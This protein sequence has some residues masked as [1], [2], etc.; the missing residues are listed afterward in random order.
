MK[1]KKIMAAM[2][3]CLVTW[4]SLGTVHAITKTDAVSPL[5]LY[6]QTVIATL[7]ISG[8]GYATCCGKIKTRELE[9]EIS[10]TVTLYRQSGK[11]WIRVDGWGNLKT[12]TNMLALQKRRSVEKG[13]YMVVVTGWVTPKEGEPESVRDT[14]DIITY[15]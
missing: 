5:Y 10:I 13:T 9:S 7:E 3:A 12:G 2:V 6:T 8:G 15:Q 1:L 11:D 4:V 14:S